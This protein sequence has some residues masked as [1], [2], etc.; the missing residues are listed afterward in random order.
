MALLMVLAVSAAA[1]P[2]RNDTIRVTLLGTG[3]PRPS[4]ERFGPATLVEA[5]ETRLLFDAGRGATIRLFS[6][7]AARG[8]TGIDAVFLSHLHSDHLVG[9]ADLWLTGWI[10][11]R[12][13]PLPLYGPKGTASFAS[14]LRRAYAF[15]IGMRR[16][17]DERFPAQ[18]VILRARDVRPGVVYDAA[19]LRVTAFAVDHAPV[20]P[21][22]GYRIDYRGRSVVLSGDTRPSDA[23]VDHAVGADVVIHE[24]VS[25]QAD[26]RLSQLK[27][28]AATERVIAHH[29]TPEQAGRIFDRIRPR[30]AV[31]SHI[32]PSPA[33]IDDL[34]PQTRRFYDG[35]LEVGVDGL[36]IEIGEIITVRRHDFK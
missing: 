20:S 23:L 27:D 24:V 10:F 12:D 25:D 4:L 18:G 11:G 9:F 1:P 34:I 15:D 16:D 29:T 35:R 36:T 33:T 21:A 32:V 30:L 14:N 13:R 19:G 17:V 26:R 3:N 5:G 22:Y 6:L 7:D 8:L 31:Y 28:P 2:A